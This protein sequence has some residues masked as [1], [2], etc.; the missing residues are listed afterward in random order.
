MIKVN[1]FYPNKPDAKFDMDYYCNSHI[2][3]VKRKLGAALKR[4]DIDQGLAGG[5]P[6]S[7]ATYVAIAHLLFDSVAAFQKAF[8]PN[9]DAIL[10]DIPNY[11]SLE[12][13]IQISETK[14]D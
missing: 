1:V 7:P 6:G 12:P 10:G 9:A 3:M 13:I 8:D 2:P 11:T 14:M 5:A 4:V